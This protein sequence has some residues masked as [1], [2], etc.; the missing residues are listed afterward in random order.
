MKGY[1][2]RKKFHPCPP[3]V[4]ILKMPKISLLG[5]T[6]KKILFLHVQKLFTIWHCLWLWCA[7]WGQLDTF[8]VLHA[9]FI[10][11]SAETA[12]SVAA[13]VFG[14]LLLDK[15]RGAQ[16]GFAQAGGV[17]AQAAALQ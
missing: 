3:P 10:A 15:A 13:S 4:N 7:R 9:H 5:T 2:S 6:G 14:A 11:A 12:A 1:K 16:L 8:I 17:P